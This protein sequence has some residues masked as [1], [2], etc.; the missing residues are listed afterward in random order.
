MADCNKPFK[1][2]QIARIKPFLLARARYNTASVA[3]LHIEDVIRIH[4]DCIVYNKQHDDV[5]TKFT[6]FPRLVKEKKT[7]GLIK[8][9]NFNNYEHL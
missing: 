4:T 3:L 9:T 8:W 7:N 2:G 1:Y 5:L 6:T